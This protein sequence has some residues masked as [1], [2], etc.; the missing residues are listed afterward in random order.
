LGAEGLWGL[1][2]VA[3]G[4]GLDGAGPAE[5]E[6]YFQAILSR[7][8]DV[9]ALGHG[10][11]YSVG[12]NLYIGESE[13]MMAFSPASAED[14]TDH[15]GLDEEME[16]KA[17]ELADPSSLDWW[18]GFVEGQARREAFRGLDAPDASSA[19]DGVAELVPFAR[20]QGRGDLAGPY[21]PSAEKARE[22]FARFLSGAEWYVI[23]P[24]SSSFGSA[25]YASLSAGVGYVYGGLF[26]PDEP[27]RALAVMCQCLLV[28]LV[29][30]K[31]ERRME[32]HQPKAGASDR[33]SGVRT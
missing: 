28:L 8:N 12:G 33:Q 20:L 24:P 32:R 3:P 26:G 9:V 23:E 11:A 1:T 25:V 19:A 5:A 17:A 31:V 15:D 18:R 16:A 10:S 29:L 22:G 7:L 14:I 4:G 6:F 13:R 30:R 27:T 21:L 2:L